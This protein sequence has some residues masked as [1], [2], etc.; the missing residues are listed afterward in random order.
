MNRWN[1]FYPGDYAKPSGLAERVKHSFLESI[2][3]IQSPNLVCPDSSKQGLKMCW[4]DSTSGLA[5][6]EK[7]I[8][9]HHKHIK[10]FRIR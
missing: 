1:Y 3:C 6:I 2:I 5:Q 9:K 8:T 10:S 7:G 4:F